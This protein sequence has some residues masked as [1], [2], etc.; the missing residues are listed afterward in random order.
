MDRSYI[1]LMF[2]LLYVALGFVVYSSLKDSD[3]FH[4]GGDKNYYPSE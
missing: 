2:V 1:V 4:I 3:M